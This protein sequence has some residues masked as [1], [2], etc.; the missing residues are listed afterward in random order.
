M[1]RQ[2]IS[3]A[4]YKLQNALVV[5]SKP[6]TITHSDT[7]AQEHEQSSRK[8]SRRM[9]VRFLLHCIYRSGIA[10]QSVYHY[11]LALQYTL[12]LSLHVLHRI[13]GYAFR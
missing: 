3:G 4:I 8:I 10:I 7:Q 6:R 1:F 11:K 13:I 9:E 5:N 12:E 2:N